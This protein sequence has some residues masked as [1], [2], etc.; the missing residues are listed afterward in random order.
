MKSQ[1]TSPHFKSQTPLNSSQ[2]LDLISSSKQLIPFHLLL[3][4]GVKRLVHPLSVT[5]FLRKEVPSL[6]TTVQKLFSAFDNYWLLWPQIF[7]SS[8]LPSDVELL[9]ALFCAVGLGLLMPLCEASMQ[10]A[11]EPKAFPKI[12]S[13]ANIWILHPPSAQDMA[14]KCI[15]KQT[16]WNNQRYTPN[17]SQVFVFILSHITF[18]WR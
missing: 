1:T 18:E 10:A 6:S 15:L 16:Q 14:D 5:S 3:P 7:S 13:K 2:P 8:N 17:K 12:S 9:L 11:V 4:Y